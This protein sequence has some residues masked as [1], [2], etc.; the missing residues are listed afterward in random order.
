MQKTR[1]VALVPVAILAMAATGAQPSPAT[2]HAPAIIH[3]RHGSNVTSTNWSGYA[4]TGSKGSVT[5]VKGSWIVPSVDCGATP[6]AYSSFWIGID[7]YNS[8]TVEQVGTDSDCQSGTPVYYAWY[9]FYPHL[10][11]TITGVSIKPGDIIS[12]DVSAGS[13]GAY[14]VTLV[15]VTT[16]ETSGPIAGKVPSA[17]QS[18]AEWV[19]EAPYSGGVLPLAD[20]SSVSF[21]G[22]YTSSVGCTATVNG[23]TQPIGPFSNGNVDEITMITKTG[24]PKSQPSGLAKDNASFMDAWISAGP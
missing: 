8:N 16:G 9:E 5:D 23:K 3:E 15:N 1:I 22:Q 24:A 19:I 20:F 11:Y 12:A 13:K 7:G 10:S 18:S 6:T 17:A 4:I 21:G 14:T 2:R